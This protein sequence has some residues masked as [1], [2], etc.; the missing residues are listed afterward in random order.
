M[1]SETVF[2]NELKKVSFF[3]RNISA[4]YDDISFDFVKHYLS[5]TYGLLQYIFQHFIGCISWYSGNC[6][7]NGRT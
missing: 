6:K 2:I 4:G 5:G 3:E 7:S 1:P